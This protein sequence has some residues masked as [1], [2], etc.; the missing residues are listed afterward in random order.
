[1]EAPVPVL[2]FVCDSVCSVSVRSVVPCVSVG[3]VCGVSPAGAAVRSPRSRTP[4]IISARAFCP[5]LN[6]F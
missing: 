2:R 4:T 5:S 3:L 6:Y 1:M